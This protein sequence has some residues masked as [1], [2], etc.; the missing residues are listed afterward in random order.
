MN[1][2]VAELDW[3]TEFVAVGDLKTHQTNWKNEIEA[4]TETVEFGF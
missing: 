4:Q 1:F 3:I 2:G